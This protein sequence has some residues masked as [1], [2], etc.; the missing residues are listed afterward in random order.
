MS[1][2]LITHDLGVVANVADDVAIMYAGE[3]AETGSVEEIFR[4]P[5][6][7]YTIGLFEAIPKVGENRDKMKTIPGIV[8]TIKSE[9]SGCIFYDRCFNKADECLNMP[10]DLTEKEPGHFVRCRRV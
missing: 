6:H 8:P 7:P 4:S 3:I 5:L 1:L 9:P 10:I 2:L